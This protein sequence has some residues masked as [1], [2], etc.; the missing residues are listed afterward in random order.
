MTVSLRRRFPVRRAVLADGLVGGG[1]AWALSGLPSTMWTLVRGGNPLATVRAAGTLV[2]SPTAG[3]AAL[4]IAGAGAHTVISFGWAT[5]FALALPQ[6]RTVAAGALAGL[7][8][9]G[10]DLGLV[11]RRFP[12]IRAL[13]TL[14]QV[15]DHVAYGVLVAAVVRLRR[16]GEGGPH[17]AQGAGPGP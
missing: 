17:L 9:A 2:F 16:R 1:V 13:P 8:V 10:L 4:L 14:P 3:E 6:R 11:G 5:L 15:A 7:A 12:A